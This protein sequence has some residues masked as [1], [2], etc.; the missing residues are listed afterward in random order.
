MNTSLK[1]TFLKYLIKH[2]GHVF[3]W[4]SNCTRYMDTHQHLRNVRQEIDQ[5]N[6]LKLLH[7]YEIMI[8]HIDMKLFN[9]GMKQQVCMY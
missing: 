1:R 4:T 7:L 3:G 8:D 2:K 6:D 5:L 9:P